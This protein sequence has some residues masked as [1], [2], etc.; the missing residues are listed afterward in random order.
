MISEG[1]MIVD[2]GGESTRPGAIPVSE[3]EEL[4]RVIP[5]IEGIRAQH[6]VFISVDTSTPAVMQAAVA[7]GADIINDVRALTREGALAAAAASGAGVCLMHMQG[8]PVTMQQAPV[9][10]HVVEEVL[11]YLRQ[12]VACCET[13]G[14]SRDRLMIDPGIGFGKTVADN[15]RLLARTTQLVA[16][17]L[18]VLIGV[19]RKSVIG[20]VLN[21]PVTKRLHGGLALAT[22]SVLA[23][24]AI[25]RVHDVA[26][27]VDVVRMAHALRQ[28]GFT[29]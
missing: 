12:R 14:I 25:I 23:G 21:Q 22:A 6:D 19:S 13:A 5:V 16:E 7:V 20:A 17:Q 11:D 28:A 10:R 24:A 2:V 3:Q 8:E 1:A 9:Y 29:A 26:A 15:M 27:T 18:P 4:D